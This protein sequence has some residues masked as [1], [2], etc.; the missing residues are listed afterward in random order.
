MLWIITFMFLSSFL[1]IDEVLEFF[2]TDW[3]S[4]I[5]MSVT[6]NCFI[7]MLM[8][9]VSNCS[10]DIALRGFNIDV[11]TE[12][13]KVCHGYI[14]L[15][16]KRYLEKC[17]AYKLFK[18]KLL[19][20]LKYSKLLLRLK[21]WSIILKS[22]FWKVNSVQNVLWASGHF[23]FE[24]I[25][26]E[27]TCLD[28]YFELYSLLRQNFTFNIIHSYR[29]ELILQDMNSSLRFVGFYSTFCIYPRVKNLHIKLSNLINTSKK[30]SYSYTLMRHFIFNESFTVVDNKLIYNLFDAV[31]KLGKV[32]P[33]II[34]K[35][36]KYILL[37]YF[38][39]VKKLGQIFV[40]TKF[41]KHKYMIYDGPGILAE[42]LRKQNNNKCSTFQCVVH[43][44]IQYNAV[45]TF[46]KY[47]TKPLFITEIKTI[48]PTQTVSM[49]IPN[50]TCLD[51]VCIIYI[52][53][54]YGYHI[55]AT[56]IKLSTPGFYY[57]NC[58]YSGLVKAEQLPHDYKQS[59]T[60]CKNNDKTKHSS[61]SFYSY[62]STLTLILYWYKQY[63]TINVSLNIS[64]TKCE[65][66]EI[67][68]CMYYKYCRKI[69]PRFY[70]YKCNPYL[71]YTTQYTMVKL[72][73]DKGLRFIHMQNKCIVFI[74]SN[75]STDSCG[76]RIDF[77]SSKIQAIRGQLNT[78]F[79]I[80]QVANRCFSI[81]S[82]SQGCITPNSEFIVP[83]IRS[84]L[85]NTHYNDVRTKSD[86][87]F[88]ETYNIPSNCKYWFE[89]T[90]MQSQYKS[91]M[92]F[93]EDFLLSI[94]IADYCH[95]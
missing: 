12:T 9:F 61:R 43:I 72:L 51:K 57:P 83:R 65:P 76:S 60:I 94:C 10:S 31:K 70:R 11:T 92:V 26:C 86:V 66:V 38:L 27:H 85:F 89:I 91:E 73:N 80:F 30:S 93:A 4:G 95:P 5:K 53:A 19:E 37:S 47:Y 62:N 46:L 87:L 3:S 17:V 63:R 21:D 33:N 32:K 25:K 81:N 34:Y 49:N 7:S 35:V 41:I 78:F 64:Q 67:D 39:Q 13:P 15:F 50:K 77:V 28:Y 88:L 29:T 79:D 45:K 20:S 2:V 22:R 54:K 14:R 24:H 18:N 6:Y 90:L 42:T 1:I 69:G 8:L 59:E 56:V 40:Q 16:F 71:K 68:V 52:S 44:L 48:T 82:S 58:M 36:K 84:S 74:L 75:N 55:N 23:T